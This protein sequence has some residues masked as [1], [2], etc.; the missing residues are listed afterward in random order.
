[1]IPRQTE[2][3]SNELIFPIRVME[4]SKGYLPRA[5]KLIN[6]RQ[7]THRASVNAPGAV[8]RRQDYY[9]W[10]SGAETQVWTNR[11]KRQRKVLTF[12]SCYHPR[13]VSVEKKK[14]EWLQMCFTLG[15]REGDLYSVQTGLSHFHVRLFDNALTKRF[16]VGGFV[17]RRLVKR[18]LYKHGAVIYTIL[19]RRLARTTCKRSK[20]VCRCFV[21][22]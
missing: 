5:I 3:H 22:K 2:V 8:K 21:L 18:A 12:Y 13:G 20:E 10:R 19:Y 16:V 9:L 6:A 17:N 11:H 15:R 7:I 14:K 4:R 1:M